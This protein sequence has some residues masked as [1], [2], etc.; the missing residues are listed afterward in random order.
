MRTYYS[1]NES[2]GVNYRFDERVH[3]TTGDL[4]D[5]DWAEYLVAWRRDRIELYTDYV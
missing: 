5:A 2:V 1:R 3:R 4:S